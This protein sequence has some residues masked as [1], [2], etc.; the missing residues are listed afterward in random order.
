MR[1]DIEEEV[2]EN[3]DGTSTTWYVYQEIAI[4]KDI[5]YASIASISDK[6]ADIENAL[7][8]FSEEG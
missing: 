4:D 7:C 2:R 3:Q 5:Y 8:D 1:K 6:I